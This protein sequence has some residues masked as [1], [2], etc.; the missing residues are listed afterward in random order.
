MSIVFRF[1]VVRAVSY[2]SLFYW[3]AVVCFQHILYIYVLFIYCFRI[4]NHVVW[5]TWIRWNL[6][7]GSKIMFIYS[8]RLLSAV[9]LLTS[10]K[11][12][13]ILRISFISRLVIW[14]VFVAHHLLDL[15]TWWLEE[16]I[17]LWLTLVLDWVV[18]SL[19]S[20]LTYRN[21]TTSRIVTLLAIRLDSWLWSIWPSTWCSYFILFT[22]VSVFDIFALDIL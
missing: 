3:W 20:T 10:S 5:N 8:F 11:V 9:F 19:S 16:F 12:M 6:Q 1:I 17:Y 21:R 22:F 14:F 15:I 18:S 4:L 2:L 13:L 7:L